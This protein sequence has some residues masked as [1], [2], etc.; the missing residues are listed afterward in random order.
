ML[1]GEAEAWGVG[2][3]GSWLLGVLESVGGGNE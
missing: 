3:E 1:H 2:A